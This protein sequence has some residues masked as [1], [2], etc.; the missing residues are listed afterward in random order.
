MNNTSTTVSQD[1]VDPS[2]TTDS[3]SVTPTPEANQAL[4]SNTT[5]DDVYRKRSREAKKAQLEGWLE[6]AALGGG[7]FGLA[8]II[9]NDPVM[10]ELISILPGASRYKENTI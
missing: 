1:A 4:V 2:Q 10:S 7:A 8:T 6:I 3:N 5:T 9:N